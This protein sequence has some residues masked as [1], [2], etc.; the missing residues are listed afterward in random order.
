V[1]YLAFDPLQLDAARRRA[2]TLLEATTQLRCYDPLAADADVMLRS[3]S[4]RLVNDWVPLINRVLASTALTE[5]EARRLAPTDLQRA[6]FDELIAPGW[7]VTVDPM[8]GAVSMTGAQAIA[9]AGRLAGDVDGRLTDEDDEVVWLAGAL[10]TIGADSV[11]R[12]AFIAVFDD[13]ERLTQ[14]LVN[15]RFQLLDEVHRER[16]T[17]QVD[18]RWQRRLQ[19][20]EAMTSGVASIIARTARSR[21]GSWPVIVDRLDPYAAALLVAQMD[22]D[23]GTRARLSASLI[24]R[25]PNEPRQHVDIERIGDV[26]LPPILADPSWTTSLLQYLA[27]DPGALYFASLDTSLT[28]RVMVAGVN[29]HTDPTAAMA[30]IGTYLDDYSDHHQ[31]YSPP[32]GSEFQV[33]A[34][35]AM[36]AGPWL[37]WICARY[38]RFDWDK[39]A[40]R[41]R[42]L[43]IL[44][45]TEESR[46]VLVASSEAWVHRLADQQLVDTAGRPNPIVMRELS[47]TLTVVN[48]RMRAEHVSDAQSAVLLGDIFTELTSHLPELI[49]M[50]NPAMG[51]VAKQTAGQA[52]EIVVDWARANNVLP[53]T[54][55]MVDD[56]AKEQWLRRTLDGKV[57]LVALGLAMVEHSGG[58]P[59][60]FTRR[61]DLSDLDE[62]CEAEQIEERMA[63]LSADPQLT[64]QQR[65]NVNIVVANTLNFGEAAALCR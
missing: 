42:Y 55:E 28:E 65:A 56:Q 62:G 1:N 52:I 37:G 34:A 10:A 54:A 25:Y 45:D 63:A 15:R 59:A 43:S 4:S 14:R 27:V 50:K 17:G 51:E 40:D 36:M 61:L 29:Q 23:P 30:L 6:V 57:Y 39:Q 5:Y 16:R 38:E 21:D 22:L 2:A 46:Q 32:P 33:Q 9:L 60:G 47:Q 8:Q 64:E 18:G 48:E 24:L 7:Q 26:L 44:V 3:L 12:A 49:A 41:D 13:W 20:L 19:A 58:I 53:P 11:L 31:S 35:L